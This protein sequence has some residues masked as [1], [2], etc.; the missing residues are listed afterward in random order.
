MLL[1]PILTKKMHG[2]GSVSQKLGWLDTL[3]V[4]VGVTLKGELF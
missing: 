2:G 3:I 1:E 4:V